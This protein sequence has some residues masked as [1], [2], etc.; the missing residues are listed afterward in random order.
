MNQTI[1]SGSGKAT[2]EAEYNF[3]GPHVRLTQGNV[4]SMVIKEN[5]Y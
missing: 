3:T 2:V 4:G 1:L 5:A